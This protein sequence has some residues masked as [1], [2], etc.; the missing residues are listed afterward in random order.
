MKS[1]ENESAST[2]N[3]NLF[4]QY[5]QKENNDTGIPLESDRDDS[6]PKEGNRLGNP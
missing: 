3:H 2:L 4:V 6:C 5:L 1:C